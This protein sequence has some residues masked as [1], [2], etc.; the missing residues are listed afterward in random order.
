MIFDPSMDRTRFRLALGRL[1][2][3]RVFA[4]H[5]RSSMLPTA[6]N[7]DSDS[8]T[9]GLS[10]VPFAMRE[11]SAISGK[12]GSDE[13]IAQ[14]L[15]RLGAGLVTLPG[16]H[17]LTWL[18]LTSPADGSFSPVA[19]ASTPLPAVETDMY[20]IVRSSENVN[21]L[22]DFL[23]LL[24]ASQQRV[25][26]TA[27][28]T[29]GEAREGD[30]DVWRER[31]EFAEG[32]L[33]PWSEKHPKD[34]S[35]VTGL[36]ENRC[37]VINP[38]SPYHRSWLAE[39]SVAIASLLRQVQ[40]DL[41]A[42]GILLSDVVAGVSLFHFPSMR[43]VWPGDAYIGMATTKWQSGDPV[44]SANHWAALWW[45]CASAFHIA[46]RTWGVDVAVRLPAM[47]TH[48]EIDLDG[49]PRRHSLRYRLEFWDRFL[50]DISAYSLR[51]WD[52]LVSRDDVASAISFQWDHKAR[53]DATEDKS[54]VPFRLG[55]RHISH[56]V[57]D[58]AAIRSLLDSRGFTA[59]QLDLL[60]TGTSVL[61][62]DDHVPAWAAGD[63]E[64]FQATEVWRRLGGA[65]ACG[66]TRVGLQAWMSDSGPIDP[67]DEPSREYYGMG[68][69]A[70]AAKPMASARRSVQRPAWFAFQRLASILGT[71]TSGELLH[72]DFLPDEVTGSPMKSATCW[73][74]STTGSPQTAPAESRITPISS[75]WIRRR[76]RS[77]PSSSWRAGS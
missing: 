57:A 2:S 68:L 39:L 42:D 66:A 41:A 6:A 29:E 26:L 28:H 43:C 34:A 32:I 67:S 19:Q 46:C 16:R 45:S 49:T 17:D 60:Q 48:Y 38:S 40:D 15:V 59:T 64:V 20:D 25:V 70:D 56:M 72:P 73:S 51:T 13:Q 54:Q 65:L 69:R 76:T 52:G 14:D 62:S 3:P 36:N 55:P 11:A 44:T 77:G 7:P 37:D 9:L 12:W 30:S 31:H 18:R 58:A 23:R 21:R 8:R 61:D 75:S 10:V 1:H 71:V 50:R 63:R 35:E 53:Q 74:S 33:L 47:G 27:L 5:R 22:A 24:A 4:T